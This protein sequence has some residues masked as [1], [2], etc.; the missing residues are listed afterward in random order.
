MVRLDH[1]ARAKIGQRDW[2]PARNPDA[3]AM[4]AVAIKST[5]A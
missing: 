1:L 4:F 5:A 2:I 3:R